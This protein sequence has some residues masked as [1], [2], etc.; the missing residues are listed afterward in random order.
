MWSWSAE[1][2]GFLL[3]RFEVGHDGESAE[4]RLK[5]SA[6]TK[7]EVRRRTFVELKID[8]EVH[9]HVDRWS[10]VGCLGI[11]KRDHCERQRRHLLTRQNSSMKKGER[12][13]QSRQ[14]EH[15]HRRLTKE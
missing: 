3:S 13:L 11:R 9:L 8:R 12:T 14:V 6:D 15:D 5:H 2:A 4:E 10:A 1:R 7:D